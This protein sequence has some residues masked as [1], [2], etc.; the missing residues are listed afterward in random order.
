MHTLHTELLVEVINGERVYTYTYSLAGNGLYIKQWHNN[1]NNNSIR[2][3]YLFSNSE[4]PITG[5]H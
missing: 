5:E 1:N 2:F 3:L 4:W